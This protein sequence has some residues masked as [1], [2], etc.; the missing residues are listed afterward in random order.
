MII[1]YPIITSNDITI[2]KNKYTITVNGNEQYTTKLIFELLY[3]LVVNNQRIV[4]REELL[5]NVWKNDFI[6]ARTIDVHVKKLRN[7]IGDDKII[8]V[9]KV[10][11]I[12]KSN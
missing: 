11:Y 4:S 8:T 6:G 2:N 10:G 7:L 12:W 5:E 1:E 3:Y 9:K